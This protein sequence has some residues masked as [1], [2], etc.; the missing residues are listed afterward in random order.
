MAA[1]WLRRVLVRFLAAV[2]T[3]VISGAFGIIGFA[4]I[5]CMTFI[6]GPMSGVLFFLSRTGIP[7]LLYIPWEAV[8]AEVWNGSF[9]CAIK[10]EENSSAPLTIMSLPNDD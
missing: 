8:P 7:I 4:G 5:A 9:L 10:K 6:S 3:P 2:L 1:P